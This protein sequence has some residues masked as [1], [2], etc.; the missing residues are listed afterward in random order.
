MVFLCIICIYFCLH[1]GECIQPEC[2]LP[3]LQSPKIHKK[4]IRTI[5]SSQTRVTY[6]VVKE[7]SNIIQPQVG[8]SRHHIQ[9]T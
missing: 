8:K 1:L 7:L 4:E 2:V 9:N 6:D 5:V 3:S